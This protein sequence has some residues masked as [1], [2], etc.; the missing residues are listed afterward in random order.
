MPGP[1]IPRRTVL[2]VGGV[3]L[4]AALAGCSRHHR[5]PVQPAIGSDRPSGGTST[6]STTSTTLL[7]ADAATVVDISLLRTASSIE[8]YTVGVY[9]QAAGL[10]V[11]G[12][13]DVLDAVRY[14][15]DQHSQHAGAFEQATG[16]AG[17]APFTKPNPVLS[18]QGTVQLAGLHSPQD[19]LRFAY[20]LEALAAST[21]AA[22]AGRFSAPALNAVVTSVGAVDARHLAVLGLYLR[23]TP[24]AAVSP[25]YPAGGFQLLDGEFVPGTGL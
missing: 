3:S 4:A 12:T 25:P 22:Y 1:G 21:Y 14:F 7:P 24:D 18:A 5:P 8:H 9:T 20:D 19:V 17:G 23:G 11:V 16:R 2:R 10:D 13:G 15:A 6:T